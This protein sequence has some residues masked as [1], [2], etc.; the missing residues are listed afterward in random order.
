MCDYLASFSCLALWKV[1]VMCNDWIGRVGIGMQEGRQAACPIISFSPNE[2]IEWAYYS[3]TT[4]IDTGFFP[5]FCQSIWL[6]IAV[7]M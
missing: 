6:L 5:F 3:P 7:R 1:L 2:M 4:V